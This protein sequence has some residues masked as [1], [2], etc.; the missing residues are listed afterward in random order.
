MDIQNNSSD[1]LVLCVATKSPQQRALT[2][3]IDNLAQPFPCKIIPVTVNATENP[4]QAQENRWSI[5]FEE[6]REIE[7]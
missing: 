2:T 1:T 6:F 4:V 7:L 3:L 5:V